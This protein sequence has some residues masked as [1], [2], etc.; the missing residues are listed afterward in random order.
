MNASLHRRATASARLRENR[1]QS[2]NAA[3]G[4]L[5]P[6]GRKSHSPE[7]RNDDAT[8]RTRL[9][10]L[11]KQKRT[12]SQLD[13]AASS[14]PSSTA[15]A[16]D[17]RGRRNKSAKHRT[18]PPPESEPRVSQDKP[19]TRRPGKTRRKERSPSRED[20]GSPSH[21]RRAASPDADSM[22]IVEDRLGSG[23][24]AAVDY[25]R[26]RDELEGLRKVCT[27]MA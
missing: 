11:L 19:S 5:A 8:T 23:S 1:P 27:L 21:A 4:L 20:A 12:V 15:L 17:E 24:L 7:G 6:T 26:I 14:R 16:D 18:Q 25:M 13:N 10:R 9:P 2:S 22:D 3:G